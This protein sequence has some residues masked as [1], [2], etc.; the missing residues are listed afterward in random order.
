MLYPVMRK[1]PDLQIMA[2]VDVI[3][4][5]HP[6]RAWIFGAQIQ[7]NHLGQLILNLLGNAPF[8]VIASSTVLAGLA[9]GVLFLFKPPEVARVT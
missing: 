8:C 1:I 7:R 3:T 5:L 9:L 2:S 4:Y 6:H